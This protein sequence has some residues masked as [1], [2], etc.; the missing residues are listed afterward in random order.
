M[1]DAEFRQDGFCAPTKTFEPAAHVVSR[2]QRPALGPV[3]TP[4]G[5]HRHNI[6]QNSSCHALHH[7]GPVVG[8]EG[9]DPGAGRRHAMKTERGGGR[10]RTRWVG[11]PKL[12]VRLH[13]FPLKLESV[14][15]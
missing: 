7:Q 8:A 6:A 2:R 3:K 1:S 12:R 10:A 9:E 4:L 14:D 15:R 11:Q 13:Q 5:S